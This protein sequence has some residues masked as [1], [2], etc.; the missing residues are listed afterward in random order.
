[1]LHPDDI[2]LALDIGG[3]KLM[4][5]LVT[6]QGT[7]L[8]S[9]NHPWERMPQELLLQVIQEKA[10]QLLAAYPRYQP[11]AIGVTIPGLADPKRGLW[12]EASFSGIRNFAISQKLTQQFGLPAYLDN[13]AQACALAEKYY[14]GGKHCHH[15]LYV[16][17]SNGVGGALF[18]DGKLYGG[19]KGHAGEIGHCVVVEE[20]RRCNC[21]SKGCLEMYA[22]GPGVVKNYRELGGDAQI[23]GQPANAQLIAQLARTGD[24][25]ARKTFELEG[26][27]LGKGIAAACNLLNPEKVIVGGGISQAFDLFEQSLK[28][29]LHQSIYQRA[30]QGIVIEPSPLCCHGGLLGAVALVARARLPEKGENYV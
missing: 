20:G 10:S 19:D 27:Y 13:D 8:C 28:D 3:S 14:G 5:G 1:M 11:S 30:N 16:T 18:L 17:V 12:I 29:T 21:G 9:A 2:V 24:V 23:S 25:I 15:Y 26:Y 4:V 22:A 7:I 6:L